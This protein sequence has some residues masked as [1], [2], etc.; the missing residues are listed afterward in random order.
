MNG[1]KRS[2]SSITL[3]GSCFNANGHLI[4]CEVP[5]NIVATPTDKK[6][7]CFVGFNSVISE[8]RHV[9]PLGKLKDTKFTS[10]FRFKCWWTTLWVGNKGS[11]VEYETQMIMLDR[12][13]GRPYVLLLPVIEG[14]F[15][16]SLQ[17]G[18]C[19]DNVDLCVESGSTQVMNTIVQVAV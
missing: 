7:G 5:S 2:Y 19:N 18:S 17:A 3:E 6:D 8:S 14:S 1:G 13:S 4:F 12:Y 11:D 10:L 16:T 9:V 15:S